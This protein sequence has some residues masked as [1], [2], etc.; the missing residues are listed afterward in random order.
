MSDKEGIL[1]PPAL[2]IGRFQPFHKGH[3][4]MISRI[5]GD[6]NR[7][8][9]GV[10]SAQY[11][12]APRNPFTYEERRV[13]IVRSLE[14][15]GIESFEVVRIDDT[16]DH[17]IWVSHVES[18]VP[19]FGVVFS[20]DPVTVQLFRERGYDVR[21]PPLHRREDYSGTEVRERMASEKDWENLV[22]EAVVEFIHEIDGAQ[23]VREIVSS[24]GS[25]GQ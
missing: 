2:F 16:N 23:R 22:P 1:E 25:Q 14:Q 10:G 11:S 8:I 20:N 17:S 15:E 5:L 18:V 6:F 4:F 3:L 13:M 24:K 7:L 21:E 12:N 9:I 19:E